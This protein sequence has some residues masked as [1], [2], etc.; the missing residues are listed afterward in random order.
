MGHGPFLIQIQEQRV[1]VV[2]NLEVLE[3]FGHEK[4]DKIHKD[5]KVRLSPSKKI[6][7]LPQW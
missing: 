4:S 3:C 2:Y 5:F 6:S 1:R 7:Y